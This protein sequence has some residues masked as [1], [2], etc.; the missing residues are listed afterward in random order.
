[1]FGRIRSLNHVALKRYLSSEETRR[2]T[3]LSLMRTLYSAQQSVVS[4]ELIRLENMATLYKAL[5]GGMR[6]ETQP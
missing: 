4:L 3:Q 5:G 1:V 6:A 2:S